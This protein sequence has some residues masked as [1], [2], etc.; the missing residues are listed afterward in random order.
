MEGIT[1]GL[2]GL[3]STLALLV[4][5]APVGVALGGPAFVGIWIFAGPR[6]AW[7]MLSQVPYE[8]MAHWTLSSI[9]MFLLMGYV[10]YHSKITEGLFR[11]AQLWLGRL[12]GGLAVATV[13]GA[14]GFSAVTGSSLAAA[15]MG[16]IA[17]P[18][19]TRLG[20][21]PGFAAGTLAAAGTIG[22]IIPPSILM[23]VFGIFAEVSIRELFIAGVAPGLL[24]A[25]VYCIVIVVRV[26]FKPELAP[27]D[28]KRSSAKERFKAV[29][30]SWP[31]F[32]LILGVFGGLFAGVFTPT[33]AGA[34]GALLS[35]VIAFLK[36]ALTLK[37][38]RTSVLETLHSTASIFFIAIGAALLTR[39][40]SFTGIPTFMSEL[41]ITMELGPLALIFAI[42]GIYILLGMFLDPLGCM[43][44]TLPILEVQDIN[45]IWFGILLMKFL[46][47]GLITP[48]VGLNVFVIK[49]VM[50]DEVSVAA[51]FRGV[52]WFIVGDL[53][54]ILAL[55]FVPA[56][57]L[58]LPGLLN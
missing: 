34:V 32:L 35:F 13:F 28:K 47:I 37:V 12:P 42:A 55:I 29:L 15:A 5:R 36:R 2:F 3:A 43:L 39:F 22:S 27:R 21:Q 23:I 54:L 40:L 31:F 51:I 11:A 57:V 17:A 45:L 44:L 33:E 18:E 53:F 25:L 58:F 16:R 20:Y 24:T 26:L 19:M 52:S 1:L 30:E 4:L 41:I 49:G 7:G 10:C 56:I 38:F 9:P 46:E 6:A 14:A 48:P 8:F 50:G